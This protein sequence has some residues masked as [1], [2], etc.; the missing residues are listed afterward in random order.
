MKSSY[1]RTKYWKTTI[2]NRS[3]IPCDICSLFILAFRGFQ[4]HHEMFV[5]DF[6]LNKDDQGTE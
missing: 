4:E 2:Q 6:N 5:E 3:F 1:G